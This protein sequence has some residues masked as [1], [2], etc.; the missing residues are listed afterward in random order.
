MSD[1]GQQNSVVPFAVVK[2]SSKRPPGTRP[3]TLNGLQ[4]RP[5]ADVDADELVRMAAALPGTSPVDALLRQMA[6]ELA[7][8]RFAREAFPPD[9]AEYAE[10]ATKR[11][12]A[13]KTFY[14]LYERRVW[15]GATLNPRSEGL[16]PIFEIW[17][18]R[19]GKALVLE[20]LEPSR[21]SSLLQRFSQCLEGWEDEAE[22]RMGKV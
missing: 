8:L 2:S 4:Q 3:V 6:E 11:V 7:H 10:I 17:I 20:G 18:E 5:R 9:A 19:L 16:R 14:D 21:Q 13:L 12:R 1:S 15:K 22:A